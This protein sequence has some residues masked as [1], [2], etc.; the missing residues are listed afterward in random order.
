MNEM[1]LIAPVESR[2]TSKHRFLIMI[3]TSVVV[4]FILVVIAMSLYNASGAAQVD[5]SRPGYKT[6]KA[7]SIT[8]D[9]NLQRYP[10]TGAITQSTIDDFKKIYDQQ[11]SYIKTADAFG[12]DPL[13]PE[14]LG[15]SATTAQ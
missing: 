9:N 3:A 5:L 13:S 1:Q 7:E 12:G 10:S 14:S 11:V 6:V 2:L 4:A 8:G 15:I